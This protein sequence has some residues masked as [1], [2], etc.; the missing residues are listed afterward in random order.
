MIKCQ[1]TSIVDP[2]FEILREDPMMLGSRIDLKYK[3]KSE[4]INWIPKFIMSG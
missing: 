3:S 4:I 1:I 2:L